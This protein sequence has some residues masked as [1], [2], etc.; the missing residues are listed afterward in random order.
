MVAAFDIF[1]E[2]AFRKLSAENP[3][4]KY[5]INKSL[6]EAWSAC[7]GNLTDEEIEVLIERRTKLVQKFIN[8]MKNDET[9][10][11]SISQA[12]QKVSY[13]FTII[14]HIIEEVLV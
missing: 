14:E 13:R 1:G 8:C 5:P 4:K 7:L 9:F 12:S 2:R 6:F 3:D 11:K 10:V